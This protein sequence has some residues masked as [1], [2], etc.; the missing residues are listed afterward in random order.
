MNTVNKQISNAL[1]QLSASV[2]TP[3]DRLSVNKLKQ[4][5]KEIEATEATGS[6]SAGG[7]VGPLSGPKMSMFSDEAPKRIKPKG[8]FVEVKENKLEG[9]VAD[10]LTIGDL[11]EKFKVSIDYVYN[12][13]V[14]GIKEEM[15][16]TDEIA[17]AKEIA[18]D[19]LSKDIEYYTKLKK[20]EKGEFKEA[21]T[22]AS[23]G[24]YET[25]AFLAKSMSKKNW[26][27]A[28]KPLYKGGQFVRVKKKCKTFPYCN[29]GD[30][31]ALELWEDDVMKEAIQNV[32]KNKQISENVVRAIVL[33]EIER[34]LFGE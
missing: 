24:S 23:S 31:K 14:D 33:H 32:A 13:L 16:H 18:M 25:P 5:S 21:T 12:K 8:G 28:A 10:K 22:S 19:H 4:K 7:F 9:G 17:I 20:V 29:Q 1:D 34:Q 26:R 2:K 6:G 11:S 30:I 27:G 3:E 15:E